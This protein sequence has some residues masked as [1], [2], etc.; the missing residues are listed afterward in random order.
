VGD[1]V[2]DMDDIYVNLKFLFRLGEDLVK[3]PDQLAE[4]RAPREI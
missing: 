2:T 4:G 3:C 1:G